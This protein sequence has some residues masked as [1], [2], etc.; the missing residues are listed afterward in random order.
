M[1]IDRY[2]D[3][4]KRI[5]DQFNAMPFVVETQIHFDARP[6]DQGYLNG[7]MRFI[8]GSF[9]H[10][11]EFIDIEGDTVHKPAYS[12]HYQDRDDRMNFRYDNARHKSALSS[13]DHKHAEDQI[14]ETD[15]PTLEDAL[16]EILSS[17]LIQIPPFPE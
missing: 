2:F 12:Y 7:S 1:K 10:F 13:L 5:L 16:V 9:F 11:R 17:D 14:V 6:G 8:D 4:I 15:G 3:K